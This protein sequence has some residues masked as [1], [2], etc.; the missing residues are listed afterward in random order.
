MEYVY[1]ALNGKKLTK[2]EFFQYFE[3]KVAKTIS[4]FNLIEHG[5]TICI[6]VSGGKDSLVLL[7]ILS[8]MS[9]KKNF[10]IEAILI[11]E[12]I[13]DYREK[14][15]PKAQEVC[16]ANEVKLNIYSYEN[17]FG[18]KL[19]RIVEKGFHPCSVCGVFRRKLLNK[20]ARKLNATKLA[21]GHNL[22]DEAQA[23]LMNQYKNNLSLSARMGPKNGIVQHD[24][25][26]PRIKPLYLCTE[27]EIMIYAFLNNLTDNFTECKYVNDSFR[28][29]VQ[30]Q[31]NDMEEKHPGSKQGLINSYLE[32]LPLLRANFKSDIP[33]KACTECGEPCMGDTCNACKME[34]RLHSQPVE[35]QI[36]ENKEKVNEA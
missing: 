8:K 19:D 7:H 6:G 13:D 21:T 17:E 15:I 18:Q 23:V 11:D 20:Y 2:V 29:T 30:E 24:G 26:I 34:A 10:K 28:K 22:D 32:N 9:K 5:D 35:L 25:F 14:T 3:R 36:K 27:K 1:K 33:I 16:D 12:G 4:R 31:L